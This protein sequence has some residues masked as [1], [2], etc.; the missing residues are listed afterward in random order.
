MSARR[1]FCGSQLETKGNT[2]RGDLVAV[3]PRRISL[4]TRSADRNGFGARGWQTRITIGR[5]GLLGHPVTALILG[6]ILAGISVS[7]KLSVAASRLLFCLAW[8]VTI[9]AIRSQPARRFWVGVIGITV[10]LATLFVWAVPENVPL[11][12]GIVTPR[13]YL[14]LSTIENWPTIEIGNSGAILT[15]PP[16]SPVHA[17]ISDSLLTIENIKGNTYLSVKMFDKSGGIVAEMVHNEWRESPSKIWDRN[18]NDEAVE[19]KGE[20][21]RIVLKVRAL[22]DRL[23]LE[24]EFWGRNG[25]GYRIVGLPRGGALVR[26][27]A[28]DDPDEPSI[29]PMFKY[30]SEK[31]LGELA[32]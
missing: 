16:G 26:L 7:G 8:I 3:E 23:Q 6:L 12:F 15:S 19:I 2:R 32:N 25:E 22:F 17:L 14:F 4:F 21:G 29:R 24:G 10:L 9:W 20:A 28:D 18:Y 30:P 13:R 31:Y 5:M 1:R 11:S 27:R